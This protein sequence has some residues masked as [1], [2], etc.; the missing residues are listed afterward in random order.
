MAGRGIDQVRGLA[1]WVPILR[2]GL[3]ALRDV[4][5]GLILI[6]AVSF[7]PTSLTASWPDHARRAL[8]ITRDIRT[9]LLDMLHDAT[10]GAARLLTGA[11]PDVGR[12]PPG[13]LTGP[14]PDVDV[15]GLGPSGAHRFRAE[16]PTA[17]PA[18][19]NASRAALDDLL[20]GGD[21]ATFYCRC[22]F[23]RHGRTDLAACGLGVLRGSPRAERVEAAHVLPPEQLAQSLRCWHTPETFPD[24]RNGGSLLSGRR[25]CERVDKT[26]AAAS[27]D[28]HNL[29]PA[30]GAINAARAN[31]AW[32]ELE[33]GQQIGNCAMRFD[34]IVR[35]VQPP[36]AV[37][38]D[39]AR[40]LLY[41]HDTY[42]FRLSRQDRR[43]YAA[44]NNLDPPD[45]REMERN[46]RIRRI[47][48]RGNRYVET[49]RTL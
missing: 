45:D 12:D 37:R 34:P 14:V 24:C 38:G 48:G 33:S 44:W 2:R 15:R 5:I 19:F 43:L 18:D 47:Q 22:R 1:R 42:G 7:L 32:G 46:R 30:V 13:A 49:Y 23:D 11:D 36:E 41:M 4:A 6:S 31:L 16:G 17:I 10:Q 3:T 35:R 27:T 28:L 8:E 21:A 20:H 25:C 29:V 40:I 39:V 9:L 26:F